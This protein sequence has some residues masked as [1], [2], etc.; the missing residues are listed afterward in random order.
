MIALRQRGRDL[1]VA[2]DHAALGREFADRLAVAR[3]EARDGVSDGSRRA[4]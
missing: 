1:V 2:D 3:E 4:R